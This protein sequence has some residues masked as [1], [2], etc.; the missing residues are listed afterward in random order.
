MVLDGRGEAMGAI[1][2][3]TVAVRLFAEVDEAFAAEEGV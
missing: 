3:A 1:C 2:T